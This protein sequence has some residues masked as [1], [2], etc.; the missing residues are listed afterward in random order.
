MAQK[1]VLPESIQTALNNAQDLLEEVFK[2][3]GIAFVD[4]VIMAGS[5]GRITIDKGEAKVRQVVL[6]SRFRRRGEGHRRSLEVSFPLI[7]NQYGYWIS[8]D[9]GLS[10]TRQ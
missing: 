4:H 3:W 5:E 6:R 9:T 10:L 7:T 2:G 1:I 8:M